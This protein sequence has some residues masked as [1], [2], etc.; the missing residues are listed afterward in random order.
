MPLSERHLI[1]VL[2]RMPFVET[3]EL[4]SI[5]GEPAT[6]VH[7]GLTQ[8]LAV[9]IAERVRHGTAQLPSSHRYYLTARGI[10]EAAGTLGFRTPS[11]FVHAYP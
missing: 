6:S 4:A 2:S 10:G 8:L 3:L 1:D 11:D 7:R 9:G 5:L